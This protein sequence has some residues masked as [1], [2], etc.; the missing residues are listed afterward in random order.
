MPTTPKRRKTSAQ[1]ARDPERTKA[2]ILAAAIH[3]FREQGYDGARIDA[4][5]E[6]S[7]FNKR[8]IYHY[9]GGKDELYLAAL[10]SAYSGIRTA[11]NELELEDLEPTEAIRKLVRF[12][13]IY[14]LEHPEFLSILATENLLKA[15][16]LKRSPRTVS[17]HPPLTT[18]IASILAKGAK[19]GVFRKDVD[20]VNL[21]ITIASIG[22]FYLSNKWTLSTIFE[23]S[24]TASDMVARWGSHMEEVMLGYLRPGGEGA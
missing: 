3:E 24:L 13:W 23:R 8:M 17:L 7:G 19:S 1:L 20:A 21:Y 12:T 9:F 5:A 14:F 4:I 11:E 18:R 2:V 15:R 22:A 6:R 10:E 16:Y